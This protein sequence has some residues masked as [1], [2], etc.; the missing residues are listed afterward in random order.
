MAQIWRCCGSDST[1]SL[2]TSICCRCSPK[3]QKTKNKQTNP[4]PVPIRGRLQLFMNKSAQKCSNGIFWEEEE[5][6]NIKLQYPPFFTHL[7][8]PDTMLQAL[9]GSSFFFFCPFRATPSAYGSSQARSQI[10]DTAAG[11]HHSHKQWQPSMSHVCNLH[12]SLWQH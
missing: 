3:K 6:V 5:L 11:L 1:P 9:H 10:R 2:G 8:V 7:V 12:H 4:R